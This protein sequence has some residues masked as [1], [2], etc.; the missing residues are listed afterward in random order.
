M[1][2]RISRRQEYL[3][4]AGITGVAA[5]ARFYHIS[6]LP[7]G[8]HFDEAFEN[9][10]A[11]GVLHGQGYP[12]FFEGNYGVEPTLIY[13]IAL[14]FR[15]FGV[16]FLAGRLIAASAGVVTVPALYLLVRTVFWRQ[17]RVRAVFLALLSALSL[18]VLYWHLHF[19][20]LGIEPILVPLNVIL[21]LYFLWRALE[22]GRLWAFVACGA[23]IGFGPYTYP[24]AR[25]LL[26]LV[27]LV[28]L[29][30]LLGQKAENRKVALMGTD[31]L[32]PSIT[33]TSRR[34]GLGFAVALLAAI[35]VFAPLGLY[36]KDHPNLLFQ[37]IGQVGVV[38]AGHGSETPLQT[39]TH[40]AQR[41]LRMFSLTGDEDPR[42][43]VPGRPVL[44]PAWS[45]LFLAGLVTCIVKFRWPA[46]GLPVWWLIVMVGPTIFSEYAPHFRRALGA[47][48]AV[49]VLVALGVVTLMEVVGASRVFQDRSRRFDAAA[50]DISAPKEHSHRRGDDLARARNGRITLRTALALTLAALLWIYGASVA[51]RDYFVVWADNPALYYAFDVGLQNIG[52]YVRE[53]PA[54]EMAYLSPVRQDHQTLIFT[55]GQEGRP[56]TFDGRRCLV[57]PPEGVA[58]NYINLVAEDTVSPKRLSSYLPNLAEM[59]QFTDST[60][61]LYAIARRAPAQERH[62]VRPGAPLNIKLGE[63]AEL[64]GVDVPSGP[65]E[66]GQSLDVTVYWKALQ[67]MSRDYTG[68]V[69][70]LGP[71]NPKTSGPLWAQEDGQ[72]CKGT[73]PTSRWSPGEV[74]VEPYHLEVPTDTPPGEYS[75][76]GGLY[77]LPTLKRLPV[78][79]DGRPAGDAVTLAQVGVR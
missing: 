67:P 43:N 26:P 23:T 13:L 41:T 48:P 45:V 62:M 55:V 7:P 53:V 75:L 30:W 18:T 69:H 17:G 68:F 1:N 15:L 37:R 46:Y 36:F 31:S 28:A 78:I 19:S 73:Y 72:P 32:K 3:I 76:Q 12:V 66:P 5:L 39:V 21:A 8:L 56:K 20:R 74:I 16:S 64:L 29:H 50:T 2:L 79:Q 34:Y 77:W 58:G 52:E 54:D 10:Q 9:V 70:L 24:A 49:A 27:G 4:L 42:N 40:N 11:L 65:V 63:V 14:Y 57:L 71:F 33:V 59:R 47:S 61:D 25:L 22:S 38:G 60:G 44:D 35:V 6:H 51:V